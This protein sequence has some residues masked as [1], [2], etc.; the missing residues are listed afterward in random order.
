MLLHVLKC[1]WLCLS[2]VLDNDITDGTSRHPSTDVMIQRLFRGC[3]ASSSRLG[4]VFATR[5]RHF[6]LDRRQRSYLCRYRTVTTRLPPP[7]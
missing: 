4:L 7:D 2:S 3:A 6:S 5:S 1:G